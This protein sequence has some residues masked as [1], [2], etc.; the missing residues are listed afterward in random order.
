[1]GIIV[2]QEGLAQQYKMY[3]NGNVVESCQY[4]L[5]LIMFGWETVYVDN[6]AVEITTVFI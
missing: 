6:C 4:R 2:C 1:M 5:Q 3:W